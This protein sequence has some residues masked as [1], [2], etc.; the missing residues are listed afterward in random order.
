MSWEQ[1]G[2]SRQLMENTIR[3]C[4]RQETASGID[5]GWKER[6]GVLRRERRGETR[7]GERAGLDWVETDWAA[8]D[9]EGLRTGMRTCNGRK[10]VNQSVNIPRIWPRA[11]GG[12]V[13][14][15]RR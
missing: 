11:G 8:E 1:I 2:R 13:E 10:F 7:I 12:K 5:G 3:V 14:R 9:G 6:N 4:R 15:T